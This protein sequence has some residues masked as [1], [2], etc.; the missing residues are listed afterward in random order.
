MSRLG[1]SEHAS[2]LDKIRTSCFSPRGSGH[3]VSVVSLWC[4]PTSTV[5]SS[6]V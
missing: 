3:V 6:R 2:P 5:L 4:I 1:V